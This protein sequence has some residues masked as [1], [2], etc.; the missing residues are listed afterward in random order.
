MLWR[1][2]GP[3]S[4]RQACPFTL[5]SCFYLFFR[6]RGWKGE[7]QGNI[8]V[9]FA[10]MG[11][12]LGTWLATQAYALTGNQNAPPLVCMPALN[13]LSLTS[14]G[15]LSISV[16]P[17][18]PGQPE[19]GGNSSSLT[20]VGRLD[21]VLVFPCYWAQGHLWGERTDF[22]LGLGLGHGGQWALT[23]GKSG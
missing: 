15:L 14:Q 9:W 7:R 12:L 16:P 13:P 19:R 5:F 18:Q 10:L 17:G 4:G 8:N 1:A 6:P 22:G 3:T 23:K 21:R 11:P 2:E 20:E